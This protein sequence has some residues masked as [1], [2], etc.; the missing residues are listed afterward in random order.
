[1]NVLTWEITQ[2]EETLIL[3]TSVTYSLG[4]ESFYKK[5]KSDIESSVVQHCFHF[6]KQ[7]A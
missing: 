2:C 7:E 3:L 5:K 6:S 4:S 1:M